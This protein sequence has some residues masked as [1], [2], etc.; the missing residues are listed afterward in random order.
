LQVTRELISVGSEV[1][2]SEQLYPS[3]VRLHL[4][5]VPCRPFGRYRVEPSARLTA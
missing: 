3:T 1:R 2:F 4:P 5:F